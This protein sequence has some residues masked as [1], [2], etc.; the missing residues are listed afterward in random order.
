MS[1]VDPGQTSRAV[2]AVLAA[3]AEGLPLPGSMAPGYRSHGW[4]DD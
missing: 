3:N 4:R 2:R 1:G